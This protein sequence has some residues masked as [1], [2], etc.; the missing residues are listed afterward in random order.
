M[1]EPA[2]ATFAVIGMIDPGSADVIEKA[3][4]GVDPAAS[5]IVS[6][7]AGLASVRSSA[8]IALIRE[9]IEAQGFI[10]EPS[11]RAE[12]VRPQRAKSPVNTP[13]ILNVLGHALL[14]GLL[15]AFI[16]P[17][18]T[19]VVSLGLQYFDPACATS[20]DSGGCAMGL[21]SATILSIAPGAILGFL[22]ALVHGILR[23]G[24]A[25]KS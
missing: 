12:P 22:I 19:F 4:R 15:G 16:V 18:A 10:A 17:L 14:W 7:S 3:V 8:P 20:G 25:A 23:I 6:I 2:W 9:A 5:V 11:A 1:N 21:I 24:K 13:A